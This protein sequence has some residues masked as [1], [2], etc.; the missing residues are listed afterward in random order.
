MVDLRLVGPHVVGLG[1][2]GLLVFIALGAGTDDQFQRIADLQA[3]RRVQAILLAGV[4]AV[5]AP[6]IMVGLIRAQWRR[7]RVPQIDQAAFTDHA[8]GGTPAAGDLLVVGA[9]QQFMLTAHGFEGAREVDVEHRLLAPRRHIA[10]PP[11]GTGVGGFINRAIRDD[12]FGV[13]GVVGVGVGSVE[14]PVVVEAVV[15]LGEQFFGVAV[16]IGLVGGVPAVTR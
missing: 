9:D 2:V 11:V 5:V 7:L 6:E 13:R 1:L 14:F 12:A 16:H 3:Q 8:S 4:G 10:T 15:E